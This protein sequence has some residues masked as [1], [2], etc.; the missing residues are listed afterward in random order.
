MYELYYTFPENLR[1]IDSSLPFKAAMECVDLTKEEHEFYIPTRKFGG[2]F[3][4][5]INEKEIAKKNIKFIEN[6]LSGV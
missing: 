2:Y 3:H 5:E 4:T 1:S 6:K